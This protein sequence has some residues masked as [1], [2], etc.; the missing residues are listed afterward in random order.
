MNKK[1]F[2]PHKTKLLSYFSKK[3]IEF[4]ENNGWNNVVFYNKDKE[5]AIR[6]EQ[7]YRE[8]GIYSY[9]MEKVMNFGLNQ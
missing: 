2:E 3:G 1:R 8:S 9:K 6:H 5:V 4:K 7:W